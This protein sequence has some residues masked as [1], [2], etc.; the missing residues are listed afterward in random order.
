MHAMARKAKK[1]IRTPHILVPPTPERMAKAAGLYH[2]SV[3]GPITV[4]DAPL[5]RMEARKVIDARLYSAGTKYRH[6]WHG[7]GLQERYASLNMDG[8]FG[9]G[10]ETITD[11]MTHHRKVYAAAVQHL[12]MKA[13]SILEDVVCR[14]M[15]LEDAGRR[16]GWNNKAQAITA[17]EV[18]VTEYLDRLARWWGLS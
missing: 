8:V 5:E 13:S 18:L 3:T 16:I 15:S 7:A 9:G 6:H 10:V 4:R 14:D 17:A 2:Q 11:A 1:R 12:G